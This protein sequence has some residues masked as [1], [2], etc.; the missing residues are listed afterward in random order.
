M[1][2]TTPPPLPRFISRKTLLVVSGIADALDFLGFGAFPFFWT[3]VIDIPITIIHFCY[4]GPRALVVLAEYIPFVG[5]VPIYTLA[6]LFYDKQQKPTTVVDTP[7]PRPQKQSPP[8]ID[9]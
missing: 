9:I 6:A 8:T 3:F 1:N 4:A 7:S 5:F 2:A